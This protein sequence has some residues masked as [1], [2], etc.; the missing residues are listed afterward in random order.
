MEV[1]SVEKSAIEVGKNRHGGTLPSKSQCLMKIA[2][3][4][5]SAAAVS[6]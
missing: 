2:Q 6:L 1:G 4:A 5:P 3:P